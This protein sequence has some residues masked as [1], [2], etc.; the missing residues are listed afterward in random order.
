MIPAMRTV[1][2]F[3]VH[4]PLSEFETDVEKALDDRPRTTPG[5]WLARAEPGTWLKAVTFIYLLLLAVAM[6]GSGFHLAAGQQAKF[7]FDFA[8]D[9]ITGV[10][11]GLIATALVQS[12]STVTSITV[13]LVAGGMPVSTAI[14]IVMGANVGTTLTNTLV[15]LGHLRNKLEFQRAFAAATVH[16]F[17]NLICLALFL[18]LEMLFHPLERIARAASA[19]IGPASSSTDILNP[20]S[21]TTKPIV[22]LGAQ[23]L[24]PLGGPASGVALAL[25]GV[26]LILLSISLLGKLLRQV[27]VG[28]AKKI[29]H[30]ALGKGPLTGIFSGSI[31]T[32]LVQSSSTTTSLVVPLV[33]S[34]VFRVR[35]IYPFVLGANIGTCITALIAA[36]GVTSNPQV[37]LQIAMVHLLYNVAGVLVVFGLPG[38]RQ[39]PLRL[40]ESLAVAGAR[41]KLY[42]VGYVLGAFFVIP[43]TLIFLLG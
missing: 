32:V 20:I 41:S 31:I 23:A 33:G 37:A 13:G 7:L 14:P 18:P 21:A 28:R 17:F 4:E 9:P 27:M 12:S 42:V 15:S 40:A 2:D 1:P 6:I 34:G 38:L 36:V 8:R 11:I 30:S 29:L 26:A 10:M 43:G 39:I 5:S 3:A 35:D 19:F 24:S 22:Q 25:L 16:D